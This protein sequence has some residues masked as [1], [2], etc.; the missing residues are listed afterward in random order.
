MFP[1]EPYQAT[2]TVNSLNGVQIAQVQSDEQGHFQVRFVPG[3]YIRIQFLEDCRSQAINPSHVEDQQ[4]H[5]DHCP[6]R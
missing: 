1:D 6:L 2:L 4:I 5:T 3:E